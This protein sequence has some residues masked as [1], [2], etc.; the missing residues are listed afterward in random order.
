MNS[1]TIIDQLGGSK[2]VAMTGARDFLSTASGIVFS[3]PKADMGI[4]RVRI[5]LNAMDLYALSFFRF[6][7]STGKL[8]KVHSVSGCRVENL[9]MAF[10]RTTGLR[11]SLG[12]P[13]AGAR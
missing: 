8:S 11:T 2:F 1:Q 3:I 4:N 13:T 5:D 6:V 9:R 12:G 7:E 10:E